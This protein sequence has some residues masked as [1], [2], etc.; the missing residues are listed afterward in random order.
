MCVYVSAHCIC[1]YM[2]MLLII[3]ITRYIGS[4][5]ELVNSIVVARKDFHKKGKANAT[6]HSHFHWGDL[7]LGAWKPSFLVWAHTRQYIVGVSH[8]LFYWIVDKLRTK[9]PAIL[10]NVC[11]AFILHLTPVSHFTECVRNL[12]LVLYAT[13]V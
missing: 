8:N 12:D 6:H 7:G 11:M 9:L 3:C 4:I 10:P 1:V 13:T 2:C 5:H